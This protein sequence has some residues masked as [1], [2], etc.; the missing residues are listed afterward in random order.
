M[1]LIKSLHLIM[2]FYF[3]LCQIFKKWDQMK[4][5]DFQIKFGSVGIMLM[6]FSN[7]NNF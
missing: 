6:N 4:P 7:L 2:C 5:L 1:F 3:C